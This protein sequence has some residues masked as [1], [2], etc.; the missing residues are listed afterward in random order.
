M[1]PKKI[2]K[3]SHTSLQESAYTE[4][5]RQLRDFIEG[6][7]CSAS[8]ACGGT[9]PIKTPT[10]QEDA[11]APNSIS[12]PVTIT[13]GDD[14]TMPFS[15]KLIL[16]I[17][18]DDTEKGLDALER[19]VNACDPAT[20]GRGD[21][22]V[23]DTRYR[24]A[25]KMDTDEFLTSFHP[26]DFGILQNIEQILLPSVSSDLENKLQFRR[27]RA[28]IYKLNVY[29]G[30]SGLFRA[31][32]DTPRS[33][34]QIGSLVVCFPSRFKGGNL[35]IRHHGREVDYDW[36]SESGS[37]IQWTAFYSDCEHEI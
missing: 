15:G 25:D 20:F 5:C 21:Q 16:P 29:S 8:F 24:K 4:A 30:P 23:L 1:S 35:V 18:D 13:W 14:S 22:D 6:Q 7:R 9:I 12:P 34:S 32:A 26:A 3:T 19:L 37:A 17:I 2:Q 28:E 31:H 36:S 11:A 10:N 27:I 33:T